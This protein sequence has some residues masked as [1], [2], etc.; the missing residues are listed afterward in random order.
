MKSLF[1]STNFAEVSVMKEKQL[2]FLVNLEKEKA[3]FLK[4]E[5]HFNK[6]FEANYRY[7]S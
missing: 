7:L 1:D 3:D 4:T 2:N 6:I 5:K